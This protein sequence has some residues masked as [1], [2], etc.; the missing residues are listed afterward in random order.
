MGGTYIFVNKGFMDDVKDDD[1]LAAVV[2]H[3]I[4]HVTANHLGEQSSYT[5]AA[6]LRGSKGV[7]KES[8]QAAFTFKSEEE[9]DEVGTL[10]ATLP[11]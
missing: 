11:A 1:E 7:K 8:F 3:E 2:G 4:A 6:M 9:A 10:Y 5:M